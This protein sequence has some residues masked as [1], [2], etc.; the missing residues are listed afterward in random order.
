MA[1]DESENDF[2]VSLWVLV[3]FVFQASLLRLAR[4]ISARESK[5]DVVF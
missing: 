2:V 5:Q 3:N 1:C 4:S